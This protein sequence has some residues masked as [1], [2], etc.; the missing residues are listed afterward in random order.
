[1][2][3]APTPDAS[4]ARRVAKLEAELRRVQAALARRNHRSPALVAPQQVRLAKTTTSGTYPVPPV[5]TYEI[6]FQDGAFTAT[7]G[8]QTPSYTARQTSGFVKAHDIRGEKYFIEEGS[9]VSVFEHRGQYWILP[10]PAAEPVGILVQ[11]DSGG[12]LSK[13]GIVGLD[14]SLYDP[15]TDLTDFQAEPSFSAVTPDYE[16]WRRFAVLA[17]DID[18]GEQGRAWATGIVACQATVDAVTDRRA[19][20]IPT[21][22]DKLLTGESG[23]IELLSVPPGTGTQWVYVRLAPGAL[24]YFSGK[25]ASVISSLSGTPATVTLNSVPTGDTTFFPHQSSNTEILIKATGYYHVQLSGRFFLPIEMG[26]HLTAQLYLKQ[27]PP[28]SS[29][30][31]ISI[32]NIMAS[33]ALTDG[34]VGDDPNPAPRHSPSIAF[35]LWFEAGTLLQLEGVLV[36][37]SSTASPGP[38]VEHYELTLTLL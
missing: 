37:G 10:L 24:Q 11:N 3:G 28:G 22:S 26:E 13:Y 38:S 19:I 14:D 20:I 23:P 17:E 7:V 29:Y 25:T 36:S 15:T 16:H 31:T 12:D 4:F 9:V 18:D 34:E 21:D 32:S 27:K 5:D 35:N 8:D 1:M 2:P 6:A 33:S 30:S